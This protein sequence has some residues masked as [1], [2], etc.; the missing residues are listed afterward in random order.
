MSFRVHLTCDWEQT[1]NS[2]RSR[3]HSQETTCEPGECR[4]MVSVLFPPS[5]LTTIWMGLE[6]VCRWQH[7]TSCVTK[8]VWETRDSS[9]F[10][11]IFVFFSSSVPYSMVVSIPQLLCML[12][13]D[14]LVVTHVTDD[15]SLTTRHV[16]VTYLVITEFFSSYSMVVSVPVDRRRFFIMNDR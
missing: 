13:S 11:C 10:L 2:G 16:N 14:G 15:C 8:E 7:L 6:D 4:K 5:G 12:H 1:F 3:G 9:V